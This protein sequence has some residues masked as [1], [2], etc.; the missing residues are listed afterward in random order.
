MREYM[1]YNQALQAMIN[2]N[3]IKHDYFSDDEYI[4]FENGII[5]D[6]KDYN[7]GRPHQEFWKINMA[8]LPENG[9]YIDNK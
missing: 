1:S 6:E 8:K 2:G 4:Y 3:Y 5:K 7:M 9:W